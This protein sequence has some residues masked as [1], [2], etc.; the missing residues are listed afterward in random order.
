M[1]VYYCDYL[2]LYYCLIIKLIIM[3]NLGK[4]KLNELSKS[5]LKEREMDKIYGGNYCATV[6][7]N[8]KANE[9][10]GLCSCN[11]MDAASGSDYYSYRKKE[12]ASFKTL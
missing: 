5:C 2:L 7:D 9:G 6:G 12:A 1:P 8:Q 10:Q 4:L 3:N 11:C